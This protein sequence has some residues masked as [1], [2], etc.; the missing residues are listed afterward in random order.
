[1]KAQEAKV[2]IPIAVR[3]LVEDRRRALQE[4]VK[5]AQATQLQKEEA[6]REER[7][8]IELLV[9]EL[10]EIETFLAKR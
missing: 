1:M 8:R 4:Q 2:E 10:A 5:V 9:A 3:K 6:M 7:A